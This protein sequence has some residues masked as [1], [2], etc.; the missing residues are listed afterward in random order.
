MGNDKLKARRARS[1]ARAQIKKARNRAAN[2][3]RARI[4]A[5]CRKDGVPTPAEVRNA[6]RHERRNAR[7]Q[8]EEGKA[9]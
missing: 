3:E 4:N 8:K 1:W 5:Q 7:L 2:E 9:A 6:E